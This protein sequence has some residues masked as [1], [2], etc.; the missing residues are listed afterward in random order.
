MDFWH[1][2]YIGLTLSFVLHG[3]A[4]TFLG[5]KRHKLHYFFLTGT[6]V[7]LSALYLIKSEDWPLQIPG[8]DVPLTLFLRLAAFLCTMS[9]LKMICQEEGSWLW[10]LR[11]KLSR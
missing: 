7:F 10:K 9:Y 1:L 4:F 8:T 3:L 2:I 6:F 5:F 11:H